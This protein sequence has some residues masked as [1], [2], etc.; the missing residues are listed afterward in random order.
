M[1]YDLS[2]TVSDGGDD[3][4]DKL[5]KVLHDLTKLG[6]APDGNHQLTLAPG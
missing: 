3:G 4:S 5:S 6:L 2:G 1:T